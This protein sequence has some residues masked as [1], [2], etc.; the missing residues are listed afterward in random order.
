MRN[1]VFLIMT[2]Y[3]QIT[4][5]QAQANKDD[6]LSFPDE[7]VHFVP[8]ANNPVF[9]G[10]DSTTWDKHIRERGYILREGN[11][12]K[13]WYTGYTVED[14]ERHLGYATSTDGFTWTRYKTNPV[15]DAH[16]VEDM[17]VVNVDGTY[18]MFAEG[19]SDI[20]HLLTSTNG[21]QWNEKGDLDI[22]KVNGEPI[23][24]GAFGTPAIWH[25]NGKWYLFYERGDLGVWLATSRDLKI[26]TNVQDEPVLALGPDRYDLYAVA[27]NQVIKY[28]GLY[29]AYYHASD[30][31][32][33]KAWTTNVAVSKDLIHWTK[34]P[35][36]PIIR[37]D[38]SSGIMV[39]DGKQ[40]RLYTMHPT[41][42][43]YFPAQ[44]NEQNK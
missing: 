5:V 20:A 16:W 38:C 18:Y 3:S 2:L 22:R 29:Y 13:L 17:S 9:A 6:R 25:E 27:V 21:I 26:W 7:I 10:T 43:V 41:V 30:T 34:Y 24:K 31:K 32:E 42:N 12:Y 33:W 15:H 40:Y 14:D 39:Y 8:Y 44:Y 35:G 36:N 23:S 37:T 1:F 4:F 28:K 11:T 19:R